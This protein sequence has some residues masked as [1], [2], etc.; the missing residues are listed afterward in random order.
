LIHTNAFRRGLEDMG[1]I[2]GR[3]VAIEY[4]WAKGDYSQLPP[5]VA[6]PRSRP[7]S[8]IVA[9]GHPA[10]RAAKAADGK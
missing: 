6:D 1:Y 9:T 8:V 5:L 10:A 3:S 4:R 2:E 7:L